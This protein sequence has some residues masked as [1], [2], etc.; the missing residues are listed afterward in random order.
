ME[1]QL[2]GNIEQDLEFFRQLLGQSCDIGFREFRIGGTRQAALIFV[3]GMIDVTALEIV[4]L[5]PLMNV[6]EQWLEMAD[7][8][9]NKDEFHTSLMGQM[10]TA[11]QTS[12]EE[13]LDRLTE[14]VLSG[15][16]VLIVEGVKRGIIINARDWAKRGVDEPASEPVIRGPRDGF[17]EDLRTNT[18]L[19]RRRI[20]SSELKIESV[21][22]GRITKT[23]IVIIFIRN[24]V[25]DEIVQEVRRRIGRIDIDSILESGYIEELIEDNPYSVFPQVLSTERP[26]RVAGMLLEGRVAI[27]I[28]NTPFALVVPS[29]LFDMLQASED[30]YQRYV[31]S[32]VIRWLRFWLAFSALTFPSIYIA[33]TTF[34]HEMIPTS[35]LLSIA[36]SREAVPF[37]GIVE[38]L[39]MEAAFEGLREAGVRLPRPIGQAVSIVGGLVIGQAAVQAGIVSAPLVIIVS[40]T[41]IASFIFSS[42]SLGLAIRLLRFPLMIIA[43]SL[44]LYGILLSLL[45]LLIHLSKLRSVGVPYLS[46]IAPLNIKD[47]KDIFIRAPWWSLRQR[48]SQT[49]KK[50][51]TR[52]KRGLRPGPGNGD[53]G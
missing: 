50:N 24:I 16:T 41:G 34:H 18:S 33:V 37:P 46:P 8:E 25:K 52:M 26:D 21:V 47:L 38:A 29:N 35:L 23:D 5:K 22:V 48:P 1:S 4:I 2:S 36:S 32:T 28:D 3:D 51:R 53:K 31:I 42:Y 12:A 19:I 49:N 11:S 13:R 10:M 17:T 9:R 39:L 15:H 6:S 30:Y 27:L 20:K 43:G 45:A 7:S 40:F 14:H 44:G